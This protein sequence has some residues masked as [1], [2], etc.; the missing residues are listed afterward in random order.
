[1]N[2]YETLAGDIEAAIRGGVLRPGDRLPSVRQASRTRH[3]SASTVFQAYYRLESRG[4][5]QARER[6]GYFVVGAAEVLPQPAQPSQPEGEPCQVDVSESVFE[7]LDAAARM[8]AVPFGSPFPDP[9]LFPLGQLGRAMAASVR[10]LTPQSVQDEFSPGKEVLR[11]HIA[12]R[13]LGAGLQVHHDEIVITNG[14]LEALNLCLACVARP[15][16]TVLVESPAFYGALQALERLGMRAVEVATHPVTGLDLDHL[17]QALRRHSPRACWLMP[18]FHNPLGATMPDDAKRELVELLA[19]REVPLIEDDVYGE[20]H[21]GPARVRPAK[22]WDRHGLVLHCSSFS[23]CLSPG[24]RI[25]WAAP[26]RF[27]REAVRMKLSTTLM[28]SMPAQLGLAQYLE[29][30]SFDRHLRKLRRGLARRQLELGQAICRHFPEGT[31]A[32]QPAGGYFTW[33]QMPPAVD[34]LRLQRRA[35]ADGICIAPGPIFSA[36]RGFRNCL[37]LNA[38][39]ALTERMEQAVERLGALAGEQLAAGAAIAA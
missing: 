1:M 32:T 4:L 22:A 9:R 37:R 6:S 38:S 14:A 16:D 31:T 10:G 39:Y 35:E 13:Y 29:S 36:S 33:V 27:V 24:F 20:L 18:T 23:K 3:L 5:V 15:G 21:F 12:Q 2:R 30:G 25:G 17:E 8:Q 26:G 19:R 11:R 7:V 28:A 34:V